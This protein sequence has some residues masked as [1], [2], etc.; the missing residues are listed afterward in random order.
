MSSDT[1]R[2]IQSLCINSHDFGVMEELSICSYLKNGHEFHLYTYDTNLKVSQG[3]FIHDANEIVEIKKGLLD[4]VNANFL[5]YFRCLLLYKNGGWWVNLDTVCLKPFDFKN[6]IVFSSILDY[7]NLNGTADRYT[8]SPHIIKA[9]NT[10]GFLYDFLNYIRLRGGI[11][12]L[13]SQ[14]L[15]INFF[16]AVLC[17]FRL[18]NNIK[19]PD[20]FSPFNYHEVYEFVKPC[21]NRHFAKNIYAITLWKEMWL[22][23]GLDPNKSYCK[24]SIYEKIKRQYL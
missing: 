9:P 3:V 6:K 13:N 16:N 8:V 4:S 23:M 11:N 1:N 18:K 2:V 20:F 15:N 17:N 5:D 22:K 24:D 19:R 7:D 21:N 14:E 10:E 12:R